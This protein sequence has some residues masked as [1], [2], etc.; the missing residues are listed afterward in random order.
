MKIPLYRPTI[1]RSEMEAVL[2][3]MVACQVG[4]DGVYVGLSEA[5]SAI[6]P[7]SRCIALRSPAIALDYAIKSLN[8]CEGSS[9]ILSPLA[10][11][12]MYCELKKHSITPILID[13]MK[14]GIF[15]DVEKLKLQ[16]QN[17]V[18]IIVDEPL[19]FMPN[20]SELKELG[21]PIIEDVSKSFG[22]IK[23]GVLAG[24]TGNVSILGLEGTDLM[25]AGG[26][27]TL[28]AHDEASKTAL[29]ILKEKAFSIDL[30]P[31][32]NASLAFTQLKQNKRNIEGKKEFLNMYQK[33]LLQTRHKTFYVGEDDVNPIYC[34]P[35]VFESNV[36][37]IEKFVEKKDIEIGRA[38]EGSI[39][40]FES[41]LQEQYINATSMLFR[42]FLFPLYPL[43]GIKNAIKIAKVI[44]VLP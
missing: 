1:C 8:I 40:S 17:V 13:T 16:A 14:D 18:A 25:T 30:M 43:L 15:M 27:A 19:G 28:I 32:I 31:D 29:K 42:T 24:S 11:Y 12:W 20:M 26:G 35:I 9:I 38:F 4:P 5:I 33:A 34:F 22:A 23:D 41:K 44:S 6:F 37:E 2:T 39:L 3:R 21:L 10:P 7:P 36:S